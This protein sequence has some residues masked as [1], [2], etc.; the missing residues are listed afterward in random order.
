MADHAFTNGRSTAATRLLLSFADTNGL[1]HDAAALL[2]RK[3]KLESDALALTPSEI[4]VSGR[5]F[6]EFELHDQR[7]V[8]LVT[9]SQTGTSVDGTW[10]FKLAS[11]HPIHIRGVLDGNRLIANQFRPHKHGL[12]SGM[13]D[14]TLDSQINEM[15]GVATWYDVRDRDGLHFDF[16]LARS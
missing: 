4:D 15:V 12:G 7:L 9:L 3:A 2:N 8:G 10:Q 11:L 1:S 5:W 13:L 14:A 6:A 16:R